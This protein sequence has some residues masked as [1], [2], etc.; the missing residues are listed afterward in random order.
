MVIYGIV[1]N[2]GAINEGDGLVG[3]DERLVI[4]GNNL[5]DGNLMTTV[6]ITLGDAGDIDGRIGRADV[7]KAD[8]EPCI[9][10]FAKKFQLLRG[11]KDRFK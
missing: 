11:R 9:L 1:V 7:K 5:G 10:S 2:I 6:Q 4:A 3:I 8:E